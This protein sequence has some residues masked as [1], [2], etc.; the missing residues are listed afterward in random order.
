MG[1]FGRIASFFGLTRDDG[2]EDEAATARFATGR[3][4][5]GRGIAVQ[6]PVATELP[7]LGP[8]LLPCDPGE[9]SVQG[10]NWYTS[11]LRMDED[12]DVA[13]EFLCEVV[14]DNP[15]TKSQSRPPKL[16]VNYNTRHIS[17]AMRRQV[18]IADGNIYQA[19]EQ[20]GRLQWV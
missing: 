10:F 1:F 9:G 14:D 2:E 19:L 16:R 17:T 4:G 8:V 7:S 18:V 12:G 6:V 20:Q 15:T 3:S 13:D 11:R 5:T